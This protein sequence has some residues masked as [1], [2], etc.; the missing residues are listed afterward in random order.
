MRER[1]RMEEQNNILAITISLTWYQFIFGREGNPCFAH[2]YISR[3]LYFWRPARDF[4]YQ[5]LYQKYSIHFTIR[6]SKPM[7]YNA[8]YSHDHLLLTFYLQY[9]NTFLTNKFQ[10]PNI[11][12]DYIFEIFVKHYIQVGTILNRYLMCYTKKMLNINC[13][14]SKFKMPF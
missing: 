3:L 9:M 10:I 11:L 5:S 14:L 4:K 13:N 8:N 7:R 2:W 12:T 6:Q 1:R